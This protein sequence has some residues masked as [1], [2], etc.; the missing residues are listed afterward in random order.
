MPFVFFFLVKQEHRI[1]ALY[2]VRHG[3]AR[4]QLLFV[5]LGRHVLGKAGD[6]D[7]VNLG[8]SDQLRAR[9]N[10]QPG[11]LDSVRSRLQDA[12][13]PDF[14]GTLGVQTLNSG[15]ADDARRVKARASKGFA[16]LRHFAGR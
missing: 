15:K 7:N 9:V 13:A 16:G 8:L 6:A 1:D 5:S 2:H 12:I 4:R 14:A 3:E 11:R 10:D